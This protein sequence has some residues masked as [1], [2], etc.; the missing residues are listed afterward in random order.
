[1]K[2]N[3]QALINQLDVLIHDAAGASAHNYYAAVRIY[4]LLT[5]IGPGYFEVVK[6]RG[7]GRNCR[8]SE[9]VNHKVRFFFSEH[10]RNVDTAS[11]WFRDS[12][13]GAKPFKQNAHIL[14]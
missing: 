13:S 4:N 12:R 11:R 2:M 7:R 3:D 1:M 5:L 14:P 9:S 6:A 8:G 10:E